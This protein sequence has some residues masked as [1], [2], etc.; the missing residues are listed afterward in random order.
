MGTKSNLDLMRSIAVLLV[1]VDHTTLSAGRNTLGGWNL[2]WIGVFGVYLFFVHTCLVLMWSL[3]RRA[4]TLDF[5]IRRVFRIYPLAI[6]AICI[7][8]IFRLPLHRTG[9]IGPGTVL[10]NVLLIQNLW[11]HMDILGVLWS[12]PLEMQMYLML[13]VFFVFARRERAIWPFLIFWAVACAAALA[14]YG[15][16]VG[17]G[18]YSIVPHFLPGIIAYI[19]YKHIRSHLPSWTFVGLL[20]ILL[21]FFEEHPSV[22]RG[23]IVCLVLGLLLPRFRDVQNRFIVKGSHLLATYSYGVYLLHMVALWL[24]FT[25]LEHRPFWLHMSVTLVSLTVM[26]IG[27]YHLIERPAMS[28]GSRVANKIQTRYG[29][30]YSED[31]GLDLA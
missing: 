29:T 7:T 3:E 11:V 28:L 15:P 22:P 5:Y 10:S 4:H 21:F 23:W 14:S 1:F 30:N 2:R 16:D 8:L 19:G 20:A 6:V 13:P 18:L 27:A 25:Y 26:A 31:Y 12:L 17:N 9:H 24:G